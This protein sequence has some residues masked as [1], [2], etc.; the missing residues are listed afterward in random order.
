MKENCSVCG[1]PSEITKDDHGN[2]FHTS[3]SRCTEYDMTDSAARYLNLESHDQNQKR[4]NTAK[5]SYW[6]RHRSDSRSEIIDLS[7]LKLILAEVKLPRPKEQADNLVRWL[8]ETLENPEDTIRIQLNDIAPIIG[9]VDGAGVSYI[10]SHLIIKSGYVRNGD[11]RAFPTY[12]LGLSFEGWIKYDEL[13][14]TSSG[15]R[16]A[17]MA[18]QY[19][20]SNHN[21][22]YREYFKTAVSQ[23]GFDLRRLDEDLTAGL[24]DNQLRVKYEMLDFSC[25]I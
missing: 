1:T 14:R 22:I 20:D 19:G 16:N 10:V 21:R 7:L 15:G 9:A 6:L 25:Q 18:M 2:R 23:T 13:R 12:Y 4:Q 3:C 8:G 5:L 11:T 24:I 17:F